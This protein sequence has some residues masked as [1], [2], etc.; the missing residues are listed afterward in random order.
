MKVCEAKHNGDYS[1]IML[2]HV[3][4]NYGDKISMTGLFCQ[5]RELILPSMLLGNEVHFKLQTLS[6]FTTGVL[7]AASGA[8]LV[9]RKSK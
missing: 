8:A 3:H 6:S 2:V 9:S 5:L 4:E 1:N 7:N